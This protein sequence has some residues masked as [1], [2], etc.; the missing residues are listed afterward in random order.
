[1]IQNAEAEGG[2]L[3]RLAQRL[4]QVRAGEGRSLAWSFGYFFCLL[5]GYYILRPVRDEMGIRGGVEQLHWTFTATFLVMLLAL[6]L[7]GAAAARLPRRHLLPAVYWFFIAN[8]LAF[9]LLLRSGLAPELVAQA[10][11]VWVSVFN[12]FVVSV[13][14]SFMADLFRPEQARRLFGVIAAGG[15]LGAVCGPALA[16]SLAPLVGTE[17]LLL[18][19]A[20]LLAL[21]L[22]C[23]RKLLGLAA[24]QRPVAEADPGRPLGGGVFEGLVLVARSRYLLGIC[25]FIWLYTSLSTFLYF[26]QAHIVAAAFDDSAERTRVFALI[27]LAVNGLT[28]GIQ[29][30]ATG[31][32]IQRWG[33]SAALALVPMLLAMGFAGLALAPVL[34]LLLAVQVAR[35]AG[36]YALTRPARE[37]LFTLVDRSSRYKAKNFIDTLVYRGG[38]AL[39]AWAFAGLQTLGLGLAG[40]AALAVPLALGWAWLGWGLGRKAGQGGHVESG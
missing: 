31:R 8:L 33:L 27:D 34:P 39:S 1:M 32:L 16:A 23:I 22:V 9:F 14:W 25:L 5:A 12:L 2:R 24:E 15:S 37:S 21:A 11:F 7:F 26:E 36:N 18:P 6:P 35:R 3:G 30:L 29:L 4:G 28:L 13:F 10:F 17:N 19:A 38:D 40:I 20:L